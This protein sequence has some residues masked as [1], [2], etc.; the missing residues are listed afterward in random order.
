VQ[1]S[2]EQEQETAIQTLVSPSNL[3]SLQLLHI[4]G[5]PA[6]PHKN[7]FLCV[8]NEHITTVEVFPRDWM[9]SDSW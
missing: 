5:R 6:N 1:N 8:N 9:L 4:I 7:N 3:A 2:L